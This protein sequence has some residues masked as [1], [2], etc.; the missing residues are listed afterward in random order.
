MTDSDDQPGGTLVCR[1]CAHEGE[2]DDGEVVL[3]GIKRTHYDFRSNAEIAAKI[4]A[5]KTGHA[6]RVVS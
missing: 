5:I 3:K 1:D 6:P 2:D 4:H